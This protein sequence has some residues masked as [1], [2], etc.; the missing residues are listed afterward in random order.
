VKRALSTHL[1]VNHRLTTVW[2]DR[3]WNAGIPLVE[4]FCARQHLDYRDRAQIAELGHWFHD[5]QLKLHSLHS[6]MYS[7]DV[8]GRTGPDAGINITEPVKFKRLQMVDEIKRALEIAEVV[9]F[10]YLVQHVGVAGEE[11]SEHKF[12]AA[13]SALEEISLF[14]QQRGVEVLLE[15]TPN[16]LSSAERLQTFFELTHMDLNVCLDVGHAN[17]HEGV[18]AAHR[19]LKDRIRSTHIHD[20]NGVDDSHLFPMVAEGG[21]ID[22]QLTM[23]CLRSHGEDVPLLLELKEV[24]D[25]ANPLDSVRQSF[26]RLEGIK[27]PA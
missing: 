1:F 13:F 7:D 9:P 18:E 19:I 27:S 24:P 17:M 20:N 25:L 23:N 8:W 14:A 21:N 11:Y 15:N 6:P 26:E 4:I 10:H 22:W 5:A 16:A 3:I 12:D 2:L